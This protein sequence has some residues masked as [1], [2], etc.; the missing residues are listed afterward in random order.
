[1]PLGEEARTAGA[2]LKPTPEDRLAME[3][4]CPW[5]GRCCWSLPRGG[6][7]AQA[8]LNRQRAGLPRLPHLLAPKSRKTRGAEV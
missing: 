3:W 1:M 7:G 8:V 4:L 6:H 5:E 2:N